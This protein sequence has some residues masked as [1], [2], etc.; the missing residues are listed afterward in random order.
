MEEGNMHNRKNHCEETLLAFTPR[1]RTRYGILA[2]AF[3]LLCVTPIIGIYA[4]VF[5]S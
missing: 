4:S 5:A 3:L 1:R 2:L